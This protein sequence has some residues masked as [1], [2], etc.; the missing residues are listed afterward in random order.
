MIHNSSLI[1]LILP[2]GIDE[3]R[4]IHHA[5]PA[6]LGWRSALRLRYDEGTIPFVGPL[7]FR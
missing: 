1:K 3:R 4:C 6:A 5:G 7:G 2:Q